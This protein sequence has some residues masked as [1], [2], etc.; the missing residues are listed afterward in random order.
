MPQIDRLFDLLLGRGGSDLHLSP[1]YPPMLRVKGEL[2]AGAD[3]PLTSAEII[4]LTDEILTPAQRAHFAEAPATS[5][6]PTPTAPRRAVPRQ[7]PREDH[8][9]RARCSAPSR[10]RSSRS[11]SWASRPGCAS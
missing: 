9:P 7:L 5:T 1:G 2:V 10:P 6:S 3:R 11:T 8:R 4:A